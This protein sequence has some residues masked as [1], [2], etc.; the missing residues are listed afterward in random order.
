MGSVKDLAELKIQCLNKNNDYYIALNG[1]LRSSKNIT[2]NSTTDKWHIYNEIDNTYDV[3]NGDED[4]KEKYPLFF[5]ALK[6]G[7][8]IKYR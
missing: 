3:F 5:A 2:Y 8:I 7:A 4:F 6:M 1:G